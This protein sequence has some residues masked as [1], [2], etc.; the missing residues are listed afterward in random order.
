MRSGPG[1]TP[2]VLWANAYKDP[3]GRDPVG[4]VFFTIDRVE[5]GCLIRETMFAYTTDINFNRAAYET[6]FPVAT[7]PAESSGTWTAQES[8]PEQNAEA[9]SAASAASS[10]RCAAHRARVAT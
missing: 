7:G 9:A 5:N 2:P 6:F 4:R 10:P 1:D 3:A 8:I